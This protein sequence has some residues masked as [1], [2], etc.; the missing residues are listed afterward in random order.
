MKITCLTLITCPYGVL[1]TKTHIVTE[2]GISSV[3]EEPI[4]TTR[5]VE[6][7]FGETELTILMLLLS[8]L[9]IPCLVES[10]PVLE[11]AML[12]RTVD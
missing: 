6:P 4:L 12:Q 9:G 10:L 3:A 8:F 1:C 7:H 11:L 5:G 2:I